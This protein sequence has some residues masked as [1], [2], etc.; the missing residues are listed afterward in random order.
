MKE[1]PENRI[2]IYWRN[3]KMEEQVSIVANVEITDQ[4][5]KD[6]N[7]ERSR[8]TRTEVISPTW[9]P[10]QETWVWAPILYI[11]LNQS[12]K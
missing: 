10:E 8:I 7:M 9:D 12:H 11:S 1:R 6:R 4:F 2:A 3:N 5:L